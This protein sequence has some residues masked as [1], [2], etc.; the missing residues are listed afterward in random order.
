MLGSITH[1]QVLIAGLY[2]TAGELVIGRTVP[3]R[4]KQSAQISAVLTPA[5]D[6]HPWPDEITSYR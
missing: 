1:P 2:N 4:P 6:D 5:Q 3:L